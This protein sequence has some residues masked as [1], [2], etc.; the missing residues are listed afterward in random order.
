[1]THELLL[2]QGY[3]R[4]PG[5]FR[6]KSFLHQLKPGQAVRK[7]DGALH[8]QDLAA[9]G[10]SPVPAPAVAAQDLAGSGGG[11]VTW[12][13]WVN[14]SGTA[15][16]SFATTW[17]V[18]PAPATESD[19]LIY[20]FNGLEDQAGDNILQPVLQWGV[21]G[22]GGSNTWGVASWYVD[23]SHHAFCT[24]LVPVNVGDK[25]TGVMTLEIQ[26]DASLNYTSEFQGIA[27]TKLIAQGLSELVQACET[28][29]V[30]GL[31]KSTDYPNAPMTA[32]TNINLQIMSNPASLSWVSELMNNPA[33]GEHTNIV[34]NATP[35]GEVDLYY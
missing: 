10:L 14:T 16:S 8:L 19:Q 18:P 22:A 15:I 11:W 30:Y 27:G 26:A 6:H 3:V 2:S 5:G 9:K 12:A 21:S 20:L 35:G 25:L 31:T 13:S 29:E 17:V 34:S 24:A 23:S 7:R 1:M 28:L 4:T 32:M 33:F